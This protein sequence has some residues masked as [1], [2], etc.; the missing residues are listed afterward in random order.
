MVTL[1]AQGTQAVSN[2]LV[3]LGSRKVSKDQCFSC[4]LGAIPMKKC[5]AHFKKVLRGKELKQGTLNQMAQ[6]MR[7]VP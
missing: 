7:M 6:G 1:E 4:E 5:L 3:R 2:M